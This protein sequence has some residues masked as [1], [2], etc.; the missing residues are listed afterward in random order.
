MQRSHGCEG[1][2][3]HVGSVAASMLL[4]VLITGTALPPPC[5]VVPAG[6]K[7]VAVSVTFFFS[8]T[9]AAFIANNFH[10]LINTEIFAGG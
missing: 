5:W 7:F 10:A 9:Y 3:F 1:A 8:N 6:I 4:T 2:A